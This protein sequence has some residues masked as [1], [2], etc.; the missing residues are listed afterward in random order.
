MKSLIQILL[1]SVVM[2]SF[3]SP[4]HAKKTEHQPITIK[5]FYGEK[6]SLFSIEKTKLGGQVHF[7]SNASAKQVRPI[8]GKDFEFLRNKIAEIPGTSNDKNFCTRNFISIIAEGKELIGCIGAPNEFARGVQE[9]T[10]LVS[11]LF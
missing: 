4:S 1:L 9:T 11:I 2:I 10:N 5:V 7:S 3:M 6:I 8:S